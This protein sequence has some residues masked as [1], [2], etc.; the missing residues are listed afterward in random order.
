M[1]GRRIDDAVRVVANK[2]LKS[3]QVK[4]LPYP[5]F[6]TDMQPQIGVTLALS[7]GTSIITE[8]ILKS[9][10]NIWMNLQEWEPSSK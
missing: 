1:P 2:R 6:P 10:L 9:T 3:T 8:S 5:G 7:K 4:T